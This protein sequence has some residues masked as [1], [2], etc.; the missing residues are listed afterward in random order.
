MKKTFKRILSERKVTLENNDSQ[1]S[2]T[3]RVRRALGLSHFNA[4]IFFKLGTY[5]YKLLF[6]SKLQI[7]K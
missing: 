5:L 1:Q 7:N 4:Y 2:A 6:K 3:G